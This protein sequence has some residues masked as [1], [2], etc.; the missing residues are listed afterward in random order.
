MYHGGPF[1]ETSKRSRTI[2]YSKAKRA[3]DKQ[4]ICVS[5]GAVDGTQQN[6]AI[7]TAT[8]PGTITGIRWDLTF[9]QA[10][11]TGLA[12]SVWAIVLL[13]DGQAL[14]TLSLTNGAEVYQPEQNCLVWGYQNIKN[15]LWGQ[16]A[17]GSTKTMR[18]VM[19]GDNLAF[20]IRGQA[21]NT[22]TVLG[23]VQFFIKT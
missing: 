8:F 11:G 14:D 17:S 1:E 5:H 21:T 12:L 13:K 22:T 10:A 6:T 7:F 20:L 16:H 15:Q 2:T 19:I 3:I 4:I 18:K 9:D 23:A